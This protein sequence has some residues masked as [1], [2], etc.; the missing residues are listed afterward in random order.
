MVEAAIRVLADLVCSFSFRLFVHSEPTS[1]TISKV[2]SDKLGGLT[3]EAWSPSKWNGEPGYFHVEATPVKQGV[4]VSRNCTLKIGSSNGVNCS[5]TGLEHFADYNVTV[6][7]CRRPMKGENQKSALCSGKTS[8]LRAETWPNS[9]FNLRVYNIITNW[10]VLLFPK[11]S[12]RF[13]IRNANVY[14]FMHQ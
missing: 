10:F 1:P 9:E 2:V 5:I 7:A 3:V 4:A 14:R 6:A 11:P 8:P 13:S 12:S